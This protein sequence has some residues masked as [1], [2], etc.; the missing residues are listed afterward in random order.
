MSAVEA[1][2]YDWRIDAQASYALWCSAKREQAIRDG[3]IAP[4]TDTERAWA[5]EGPVP[6]QQLQAGRR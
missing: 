4:E 5:A 2:P 6:V 1:V 3:R